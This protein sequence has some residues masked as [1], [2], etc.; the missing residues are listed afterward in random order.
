MVHVQALGWREDER[1]AA[2]RLQAQ[3]CG[4][5]QFAD[6]VGPGPG[7]IDQYRRA[8]AGIAG[9]DLPEPLGAAFQ[10]QYFAV[11]VDL[12]LVAA[13]ATQV[14]LVQ[15]VGV[16]VAGA[17]VVQRAV[18]LLRAQDRHARAGFCCAQ[19]LHLRYA[20]FRA[21]ILA[22]QFFGVA[23]EVHGHFPTGG[24]QRV[25]GKALG[26]RVEECPAGQGQGAHL[27]RAICR[28]V[29]RSRAA[30]GVISRVRFAFKHDHPRLLRQPETR[31]CTGDA[32]ADDD[33]VSL[34]HE[35]LLRVWA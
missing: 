6:G 22:S 19:Q 25:F 28:G 20:G 32:A 30:G 16:D 1:R 26:R 23:V 35:I 34:L 27:G 9:V 21:F 11:G 14:A 5:G 18:D 15:G 10:A 3:G 13:N 29:E 17:G 2:F 12:A 33:V 24:Q 8:E 7:G 31:G 4:T